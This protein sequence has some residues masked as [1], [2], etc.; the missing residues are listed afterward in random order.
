MVNLLF[1]KK[2]IKASL[3]K[4]VLNKLFNRL[5]IA[6]IGLDIQKS[7]GKEIM[8]FSKSID[9]DYE[10]MDY[11]L[12][13]AKMRETAHL[14]QKDLDFEDK[15]RYMSQRNKLKKIIKIWKEK[16]P[17]EEITFKWAQKI[18]NLHHEK[19]EEE[20]VLKRNN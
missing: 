3:R 13:G 19:W 5:L 8:I 16:F 20:D 4:G 18:L 14:L 10:K 7:F 2:I 15:P 6:R 17:Q 1:F 11:D 12:L 9:N